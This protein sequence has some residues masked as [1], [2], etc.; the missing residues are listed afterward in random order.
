MHA[1][2]HI[3]HDQYRTPAELNV[4][5]V[6][7]GVACGSTM[8]QTYLVSGFEDCCSGYYYW[9]IIQQ[10]A[11]WVSVP[12]L[13]ENNGR[14]LVS[15]TGLQWFTINRS[16]LSAILDLITSILCF[17]AVLSSEVAFAAVPRLW[18]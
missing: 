5:S 15:R 1:N 7:M 9:P 8:G 10:D 11:N 17:L 18:T 12:A 13:L 16:V 3:Y 4:Q 2:F 14:S 6:S